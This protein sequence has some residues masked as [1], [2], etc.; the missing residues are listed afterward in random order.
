MSYLITLN[1]NDLIK[2]HIDTTIF[3]DIIHSDDINYV[4][5]DIELLYSSTSHNDWLINYGKYIDFNQSKNTIEKLHSISDT[6]TIKQIENLIV[7][8]KYD[9]KTYKELKE[10][11][12]FIFNDKSYKK[13]NYHILSF[14]ALGKLNK[15]DKGIYD[16]TKFCFSSP[17]LASIIENNKITSENTIFYFVL[18]KNYLGNKVMAIKI[19]S[20]IDKYY[21]FS[22]NPPP[23]IKY[24]IN[25]PNSYGNSQGNTFLVGTELLINF[26]GKKII[27]SFIK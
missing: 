16:K 6:N 7:Q 13:D 22:Q 5:I 23:E 12:E 1:K 9:S 14:D 3:K 18:F 17:F 25:N 2:D 19:G 10:I 4:Y 27:K 21:D 11:F 8:N 26:N 15:A 24:E 20:N